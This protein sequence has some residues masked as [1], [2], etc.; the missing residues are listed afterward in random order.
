MYTIFFQ[1][2]DAD[3]APSFYVNL[4]YD[5]TITEDL[6]QAMD[7]ARAFL[8]NIGIEDVKVIIL[9]MHIL[10][11]VMPGMIQVNDIVTN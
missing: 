3:I 4:V 11:I 6:Q 5:D 1:A 8:Y 10:I 2:G 7:E 9:L